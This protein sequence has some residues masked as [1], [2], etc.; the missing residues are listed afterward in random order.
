MKLTLEKALADYEEQSR[1]LGHAPEYTR[2]TF[3]YLRKFKGAC[4]ALTPY[5]A[6]TM[7]VKAITP[8]CVTGYFNSLQGLCQGSQNRG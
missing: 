6:D 8:A 3:V 5:K 1:S 4:E 2:V 7:P